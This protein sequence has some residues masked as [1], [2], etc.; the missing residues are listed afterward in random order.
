[1]CKKLGFMG[2]IYALACANLC[3]TRLFSYGYT[4]SLGRNGT[5]FRAQ[6][7]YFRALDSLVLHVTIN[8]KV[9]GVWYGFQST[10]SI[11]RWTI[12]AFA[13]NSSRFM[14]LFW[15]YLFI[16]TIEYFILIAHRH[17]SRQPINTKSSL[18]DLWIS[19][20]VNSRTLLLL[21]L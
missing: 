7:A 14:G 5:T 11:C 20:C 13:H 3:K 17:S 9:S 1:M 16:P 8:K 6:N 19:N 21:L 12:A 2:V 10:A 18:V 4:N 15:I